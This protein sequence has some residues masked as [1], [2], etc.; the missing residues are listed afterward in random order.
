[1]QIGAEQIGAGE[2]GIQQQMI[3]NVRG[4]VGTLSSPFWIPP[5]AQATGDGRTDQQTFVGADG[6][7]VPFIGVNGDGLCPFQTDRA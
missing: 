4:A 5:G 2:I 6:L 7:Q 3:E 1:M